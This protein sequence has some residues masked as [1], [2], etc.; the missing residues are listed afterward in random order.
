M[1]FQIPL[2]ALALATLLHSCG[3]GD[4][5]S[6][7][8]KDTVT[9]VMYDTVRLAPD[10]GLVNALLSKTAVEEIIASKE[11]WG[12]RVYNACR[13]SSDD[14]GT[15]VA[16]PVIK[17]DGEEDR[18][19]KSPYYRYLKI[20]D[21]RVVEE[22]LDLDHAKEAVTWVRDRKL[23]LYCAE[24][25]KGRLRELLDVSGMEAILFSPVL[26]YSGEGSRLTMTATAV[27]IDAGLP[28]DITDV[29][30]LDTDP[31]PVVCGD[32]SYYLVDMTP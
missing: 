29:D 15:V 1:R 12:V 18:G 19:E 4:G 6:D 9:I 27:K 3:G 30:L 26:I 21:D 5:H 17:E 7:D 28:V 11:H 16:V 31:C 24:F 23:P 2:A 13:S 32:M 10:P 14:K 25:G 20:E 8:P 22:M